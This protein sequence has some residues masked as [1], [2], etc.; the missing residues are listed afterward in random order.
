M[1]LKIENTLKDKMLAGEVAYTLS[2]KLIRTVELPMMAKTAGFD[3]ILIDMEHSSFDLD[4]AGQLCIAALYAGITPIVRSPSKDPF[5]V[6]RILDGGALGVIV[7]HIKTVQDA[8]DVVEAA[9][10]HPV[11][12]RSATSGLPHLQYKHVPAKQANPMC[13]AATLVI[14][15]IETLE[16]LEIVDEIAAVPGVD[17]LLIGTNDLTAEM[18]MPGDYDNDRL[19]AAYM[20]VA[21]A[22][23]KAN[24]FLGCGGLHSRLDLVEKFCGMGVNWVMAATDAPL[25]S[26]AATKRAKEMS[27]LNERV[28]RNSTKAAKVNGVH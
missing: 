9:K 27:E 21:T 15:M 5:F 17:S 4:T 14:P 22:C 2:A 8:K 12:K 3:G 1:A 19:D 24:I 25:L 16:A 26:G 6:S 20:K 28:Q 11:G 7:P 10:F 23:K 18:D 13:N